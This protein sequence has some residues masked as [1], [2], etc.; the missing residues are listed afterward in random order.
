VLC[1]VLVV[2][3]IDNNDRL[4][5]QGKANNT[6]DVVK[7]EESLNFKNGILASNR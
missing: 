7:R 3:L 1:D 2:A 6:N 4:Q 5:V